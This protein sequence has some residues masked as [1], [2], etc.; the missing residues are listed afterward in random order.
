MATTPQSYALFYLAHLVTVKN[1]LNRKR[2]RFNK[3]LNPGYEHFRLHEADPRF[4]KE[5]ATATAPHGEYYVRPYTFHTVPKPMHPAYSR[6]EAEQGYLK[7]AQDRRAM[8]RHMRDVCKFLSA[9][10]TWDRSGYITQIKH[11]GNTYNLGDIDLLNE[12][13]LAEQA[14]I[15]A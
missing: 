12:H 3:L 8:T 10:F 2:R 9:K 11:E 15:K 5:W 7:A 6:K 1:E 13:Y 4:K 14:L